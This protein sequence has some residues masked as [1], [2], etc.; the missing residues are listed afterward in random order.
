MELKVES[1]RQTTDDRTVERKGS[2]MVP[3]PRPRP[4]RSRVEIE[5]ESDEIDRSKSLD[6]VQF[7]Q[8]SKNNHNCRR[9]VS[10]SFSYQFPLLC[11]LLKSALQI[12]LNDFKQ[13]LMHLCQLTRRE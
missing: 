4:R 12:Q 11:Q 10:G 3:R 5:V 9:E 6:C 1:S 8:R 13:A 7:P 2:T